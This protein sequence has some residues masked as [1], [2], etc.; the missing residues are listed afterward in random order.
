MIRIWAIG[1][2]SI[3]IQTWDKSRKFL[4]LITTFVTPGW[5]WIVWVRT[6]SPTSSVV[7]ANRRWS[8]V[9]VT[10]TS[11]SDRK[12]SSRTRVNMWGSLRSFFWLETSRFASER[13][14]TMSYW[15][16]ILLFLGVG[17]AFMASGVCLVQEKDRQR[18]TLNRRSVR[19]VSNSLIRYPKYF[20]GK[21]FRRESD[22]SDWI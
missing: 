4:P 14:E 17:L 16:L 18:K 6:S 1:L 15:R 22:S 11:A 9:S 21:F 13:V 3:L 7:T 5:S 2:N 19:N 10:E 12:G 20:L 8:G